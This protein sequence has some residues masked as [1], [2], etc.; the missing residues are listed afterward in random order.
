MD[1]N[2]HIDSSQ[3]GSGA[4]YQAMLAE[5]GAM[6]DDVLEKAT[7][8]AKTDMDRTYARMLVLTKELDRRRVTEA[9][10]GLSVG[11]WLQS[12]CRMTAREASGTLKTARALAQMPTVA[13]K[14]VTGQIVASGVKLLAMT[15][16]R[17]PEEFT[18]HEQVFTQAAVSLDP[19]DLRVVV[20]EWEQDINYDEALA[21]AEY[22]TWG[23]EVFFNQSYSGRWNLSGEFGVADGHVVNSAL[24]GYIQ[25]S[26]IDET[27]NECIY[28]RYAEA[29]VGINQF[30]LDHNNSVETSGGEKPHITVTVPWGVLSGAKRQL[31][32]LD[33]YAIDPTTLKRWA[34]DAGVVRIITDADS[35]PIDVG[36]R[37]R[38]IPPALRRALDYRD[39][40]CV[41]SGCQI[42][43]SWCDAHHIVHWANGGDTNLENCQLLCRRHHT[44]THR[45]EAAQQA[46]ERWRESNMPPSPTTAPSGN[47][48]GSPAQN[49]PE[50]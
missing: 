13:A 8:E 16:D 31:P 21:D 24:Q 17:H 26:F 37:T 10:S 44:M 14:A 7:I 18:D 35:Q 45:I 19:G 5:V 9:S 27:N 42:P 49:R 41:W 36:R 46:D 12:M 33:G 30:W 43:A 22:D 50:P 11:S 34:C 47:Q 32:E 25:R 29:L 20:S 48:R 1:R 2:S 15:R 6:V 28:E 4:V 3:D 38:T 40:G 39:G 23:R